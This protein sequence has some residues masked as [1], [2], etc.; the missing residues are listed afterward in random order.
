MRVCISG[1][2]KGS[3]DLVAA[4]ELYERAGLAVSR[5]GHE[6]Y[7]PHTR[8]DPERAAEL[9]PEAVYDSD[10]KA[11]HRSDDVLA[12]LNEPS[13]GVGAEIAVCTSEAI[14]VLGL[15]AVR[16]DGSRFALGCLLA[17]NGRVVRYDAWAQAAQAIASFL[18]GLQPRQPNPSS[19]AITES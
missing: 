3:R 2:L 18:A 12:F 11:M 16:T 6:P 5:A 4:R 10:V 14:P 17:G 8:T 9:A 7:V 1:A 15:C 19:G 13:L